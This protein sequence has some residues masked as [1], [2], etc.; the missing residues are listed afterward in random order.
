MNQ[1]WKEAGTPG[2]KL[3][4]DDL[5]KIWLRDAGTCQYCGITIDLRD[6]S[7]DHE[8]PLARGGPNAMGNLKL[9]CTTCQRSKH[10]R[11]TKD[12]LAWRHLIVECPIDGKKFKPR[13]ADY[14]RGYGK[15]CSLSCAGKAGAKHGR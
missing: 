7:F 10:A 11:S 15:Y 8:I 9:C 1:A 12:Y 4:A 5:A 2:T 3:V 14:V 6:A 13:W